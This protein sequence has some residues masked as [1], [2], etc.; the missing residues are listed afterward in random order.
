MWLCWLLASLICEGFSCRSAVTQWVGLRLSSPEAWSTSRP[1][2][3]Q[4]TSSA[5]SLE[6]ATT[7][8]NSGSESLSGSGK[9]SCSSYVCFLLIFASCLQ[10]GRRPVEGGSEAGGSQ[11]L[12]E[13]RG[14]GPLH[15]SPHQ[16]HRQ[17]LSGENYWGSD[18]PHFHEDLF[19]F[20]VAPRRFLPIS[21]SSI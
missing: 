5:S 8:S 16:H 10:R 9:Q 1:D 19:F 7:W 3:N 20:L 11:W 15:R 17:L 13:R 6:A 18:V 21:E 2:R 4:T 12:G 14:L